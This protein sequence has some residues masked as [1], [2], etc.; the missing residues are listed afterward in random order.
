MRKLYFIHQIIQLEENRTQSLAASPAVAAVS[1]P[2]P[3]S[4]PAVAPLPSEVA[5]DNRT[6]NLHTAQAQAIRKE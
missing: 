1:P 6:K 2:L 3:G 5:P 4:A